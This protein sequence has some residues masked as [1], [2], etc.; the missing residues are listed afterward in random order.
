MIIII[1]DCS[2]NL[3][4]LL[5]LLLQQ[6]RV[7]I[8]HHVLSRGN[9]QAGLH[10]RRHS[11]VTSSLR[12]IRL[13]LPRVPQIHQ[14]RVDRMNQAVDGAVGRCLQ[15][16]VGTVQPVLQCLRKHRNETERQTH[17]KFTSYFER[18]SSGL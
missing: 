13:H 5:L 3:D 11:L 16:V 2:A 10:H 8:S 17:Q 6:R 14:R 15:R 7:L 9:T 12:L 4:W 18:V 1:T